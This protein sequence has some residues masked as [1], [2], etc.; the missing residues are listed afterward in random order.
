MGQLGRQ[1]GAIDRTASGA[2]MPNDNAFLPP[3]IHLGYLPDQLLIAHLVRAAESIRFVGPGLSRGVAKVLRERWYELGP[4]NVE[5]VIDSDP[6]VCR[7]GFGDGSAIELLFDA[8]RN[9]GT[10]LHQIPGIRLSVLEI[11]GERIIYAPTPRLV[12][13]SDSVSCE[14]ILSP[15]GSTPYEDHTP[16]L[17]DQ[18]LAPPGMAQE[19]LTEAEVNHIKDDLAQS[20]PLPFDLA[21]QVRVL[22]THFQFVEFSLLNAALSRKRVPVPPYL[23]GLAKDKDAEELLRAS[24]QLVGKADEVSG[25]AL[26]KRREEIDRKYLCTIANYGKV[27]LKSN[28]AKFDEAVANLKADVEEFRTEAFSKLKGAIEKNCKE[29]VERLFPVVRGNLPDIWTAT[30]GPNPSADRIKDRL[31]EELERAYGDAMTHLSDIEVRLVYKNVTVEML[32][33]SHFKA[34]AKKAKLDL[35][36]L[37]EEFNAARTQAALP[38][39]SS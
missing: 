8:A 11:D 22:S 2:P 32:Q 5:I 7:L 15:G 36:R 23:L 18:I 26:M 16:K 25:H 37:H 39:I 13:H 17:H 33:D 30:L 6:D 10:V 27:I 21:R 1:W 3:T 29:V 12:D 35:D 24:F 28:R 34:S 14:I 4:D 20:P 38:F 9:L 31:K 19:P